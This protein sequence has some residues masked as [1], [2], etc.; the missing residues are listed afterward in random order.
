MS[1]FQFSYTLA[2]QGG[3]HLKTLKKKIK[4]LK[5]R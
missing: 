5:A 4:K 2:H 3:S 1:G